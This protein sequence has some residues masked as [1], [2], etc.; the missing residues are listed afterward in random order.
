V[1]MDDAR[2]AEDATKELDGSRMC[3]KR[4]KVRE[5]VTCTV[6]NL[7][8]LASINLKSLGLDRC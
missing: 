5:A 2:D 3:G 4:V 7:G 8:D 1:L 6:M